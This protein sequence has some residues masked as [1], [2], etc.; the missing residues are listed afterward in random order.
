MG[1]HGF[2]NR[3]MAIALDAVRGVAALLVLLGHA[4]QVGIYDGPWPFSERL[5]H[6]PVV[7]FFV[8]SG[9]VIATSAI[10]ARGGLFDYA[11]ARAARIMPVALFALAF[12]TLAFL[13]SGWLPY[14][15]AGQLPQ[16]RTWDAQALLLPLVFLSER[17]DGHGP[18][19]NPPYWSLAYEVWYYAI[20]GAAF[21]LAGVKRWLVLGALAVLAGIKVLALLPLWLLGVALARF[22]PADGLPLPASIAALLAGGALWKWCNATPLSINSLGAAPPI[23]WMS[24]WGYSEYAITD[25][26]MGLGIMLIFLGMRP[27]VT[28]LASELDWIERPVR[29]LAGCSFTLYL[30]HWPLLNLMRGMGLVAGDSVALFAVMVAAIVALAGAVATLTE[31]RRGKVRA[32]LY[33][34]VRKAGADGAARAAEP[35][36]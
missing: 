29:W 12:G 2:I 13:A 9:L 10:R 11:V 33:Q 14:P 23:G 36:R 16:Y 3:P 32:M 18:L 28:M 20:F 5:Q 35:A 7:V 24:E 1:D 31:H 27:F 22:A 26:G 15:V 17:G 30:L 25:T 21:Y 4:A 19:W 6:N 8:L 34:L